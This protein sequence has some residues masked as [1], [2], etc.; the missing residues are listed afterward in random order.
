MGETML[1][2][3]VIVESD[4]WRETLPQASYWESHQTT[5]LETVS[6]CFWTN[7][8]RLSVD[9]C[10][11]AIGKPPWYAA[12]TWRCCSTRPGWRGGHREAPRARRDGCGRRRQGVH[13]RSSVPQGHQCNLK[14]P[15]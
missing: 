6:S 2:E 15:S 5:L 1:M 9:N 13:T 7:E 3:M 11:V 4:I 10:A 12:T 14:H 8:R